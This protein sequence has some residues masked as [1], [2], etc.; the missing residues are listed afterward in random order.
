ML[1]EELVAAL[2]KLDP[3]AKV[4]METYVPGHMTASGHETFITRTVEVAEVE[5]NVIILKH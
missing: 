1:N 3:K 5:D 2:Q 4:S